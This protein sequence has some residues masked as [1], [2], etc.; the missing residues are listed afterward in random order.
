MQ[1]THEFT[2]RYLAIALAAFGCSQAGAQVLPTAPVVVNGQASFVQAPNQ[3]TVTNSNGA[4]INWQGF[5]IGAADTVRFIQPGSSSSV[6][7]R[8]IGNDPSQLLG[9]LQSNGQVFLI[10][11]AGIM[12][13][14]GARI[15]VAGFVASTLQMSDADFIA[16]RL[17]FSSTPG[18]GA[19]TNAGTIKTPEGGQVYLVGPHVE[20]SGL[21]TAPNGDVI[22]AAGATVEVG[23]TASPGVRVSV[24]GTG[25]QATNLGSIVSTAGRI[26]LVGALVSNNGKLNASSAVS[27]GGRIYLRA[28]A[29]DVT[30]SSGGSAEADGTK[31]GAIA[32]ESSGT[33]RVEGTLSARGSAGDGGQIDVLG[34]NVGLLGS[35]LV[36]V[37]GS[38][39]GG[40]VRIGGDYQGSNPDI[41]NAWV[42]WF[43]PQARVLAD[44]GLNGKGGRVIVWADDTTRFYG[45]ISARGGSNSGD[46]GFAEVSGKRYLDYAGITDLT[47]AFGNVGTL[48]LDPAGIAIDNS[49]NSLITQTG[50]EFDT[51]SGNSATL[52]WATLLAQLG[53]SDVVVHTADDIRI[54]AS[55]TTASATISHTDTGTWTS[56]YTNKAYN[57]SNDLTLLAQGDIQVKKTFGNAGSGDINL[58]AGWDG[59][60]IV[61][62]A[63]TGGSGE[64]KIGDGSGEVVLFNQAGNINLKAGDRIYIQAGEVGGTNIYSGIDMGSGA[65]TLTANTIELKGGS[66]SGVNQNN[67]AF[68]STN[69][70]QTFNL[71]GT[72][73]HLWVW[74]GGLSANGNDFNNSAR[75]ESYGGSQTFN[76]NGGASVSVLA[77][78]GTGGYYPSGTSA[79][80]STGTNQCSDNFAEIRTT[81][82][83]SQTFTFSGAGALDVSGSTSVSATRGNNFA[84]ISAGTG[85]Q[86]ITGA[87]AIT[88]TAG[89]A[90]GFVH[91]GKD[92]G[93]EAGIHSDGTQTISAVSM[94]LDATTVPAGGIGGA[95]VTAPTQNITLTGNLSL[96]G[97]LSITN[98]Q[99]DLA[100][101]AVI[102]ND[103]AAN[104]TIS[105]ANVALNAGTGSKGS[106][107]IGSI[108]GGATVNITTSNGL[109]LT[110]TSNSVAGIGAM[111]GSSAA[112]IT[113]TDNSTGGINLNAY[114]AL[115]AGS[116]T[117][118]LSVPSA[119]GSS[120]T[121]AATGVI[122]ASTLTGTGNRALTLNGINTISTINLSSTL[123]NLSYKSTASNA[124]V[125]A[126]ASSGTVVIT[127]DTGSG[128]NLSLGTL[129][130]TSVSVTA[131]NAI[132]DGNGTGTVNITAPVIN[133]TS[134]DGTLVAGEV[135]ISTD[136]STTTTANATVQ[137]GA[138]TGGIRMRSLSATAPTTVSLQDNSNDGDVVFRHNGNLTLGINYLLLANAGS[139]T[140]E[141]AGNMILN[142][143]SFSPSSGEKLW[144]KSDGNFLN[145]SPGGL[146]LS[147]DMIISA[148]GTLTTGT[149]A[150]GATGSSLSLVAP[151]VTIGSGTVSAGSVAVAASQK[152]NVNGNVTATNGD[153][154]MIAPDI[155]LNTATVSA[156]AGD[157]SMLVADSL[158]LHTSNIS[159][160]GDVSL[161][162]ASG[163]AGIL[164]NN[165][166]DPGNSRIIA[167]TS[168][169][170]GKIDID[171]LGRASGGIAI[172]GVETT[173]TTSGSSGFYIQSISTPAV[174]DSNMFVTYG[175]DDEIAVLLRGLIKDTL[176]GSGGP[177]STLV[178]SRDNTNSGAAA[179]SEDGQFGESGNANTRREGKKRAPICR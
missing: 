48:L 155:E 5:S 145:S 27:E 92:F 158:K 12:V 115:K 134:N 53:V 150:I 151:T 45:A 153:I 80:P 81:G 161:T 68:I 103:T 73:G 122:N 24:T 104:V 118:T 167:G 113:L 66:G 86:T 8:V 78:G 64:I 20:N 136:I 119:G 30:Q 41:K 75:I 166:I 29:G 172:K 19:V 127:T 152:V 97:G 32:I 138:T 128:H 13:G 132:L 11:P 15:D 85:G 140:A 83:G 156:T 16:R 52:T 99:Y 133:L 10:N 130:G 46:G 7:N 35:A 171:F 26:G 163:T 157:I 18:A 84:E 174:I 165:L 125:S 2:R 56:T 107:L 67:F 110:G 55:P 173:A 178:V 170:G 117:V 142:D 101:A 149:T 135:A 50:G 98:S 114:S 54:E 146:S 164:L 88:L 120:V 77:G 1:L 108:N 112:T 25:N 65:L 116:G 121:Q 9:N 69:G 38:A 100:S 70:N 154:V 43:G 44:A 57:S 23:D 63:V 143:A 58:Y 148:A 33:S 109:N 96:S 89:G 162:L 72:S 93:N 36:D 87:G 34:R 47:A 3:L 31:G 79:C 94:S 74:G 39:N 111:N 106:A 176:Q 37:S 144:L 40:Q 90:G 105:A 91:A 61:T 168:G 59:A 60:S 169:S 159:A 141:S 28:H 22:L 14:A 147:R 124:T 42:T 175:A 129:S 137:S 71:T 126:N 179:E 6:L 160:Y 21:I 131:Q 123:G 17:S 102:G 4:I 177:Q 51:A 62:P 76:L 95:F 82:S 139:V 49:S